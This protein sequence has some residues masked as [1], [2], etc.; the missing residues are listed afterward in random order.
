LS[1]IGIVLQILGLTY[2]KFRA[3][4]RHRAGCGKR[5]GGGSLQDFLEG[6]ASCWRL[7]GS[8]LPT[9]SPW[10]LI[11]SSAS[12]KSDDH[13]GRAGIARLLQNLQGNLRHQI[14]F[15]ISRGSRSWR[16]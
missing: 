1:I 5:G 12:S 15:F 10:C 6:A 14:V 8:N 3:V 16:W 7:I 4:A 13:R 9:S 2:D 11:P